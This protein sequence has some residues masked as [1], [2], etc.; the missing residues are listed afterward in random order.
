[1]N[2]ATAITSQRCSTLKRAVVAVASL[3]VYLSLFRASADPINVDV[4]LYTNV[5]GSTQSLKVQQHT[6]VAAMLSAYHFNNR[7][8]D[9]VPKYASAGT[10]GEG[11]QGVNLR[12]S[13]VEYKG[14]LMQ[15]LKRFEA[16]KG[17][18]LT[19]IPDAILCCQSS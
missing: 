2:A 19:T 12:I 6:H 8:G 11:G 16:S 10:C 1:M 7:N 17:R 14:N 5:G 13:R 4:D 15:G 18:C 3:V 9:I